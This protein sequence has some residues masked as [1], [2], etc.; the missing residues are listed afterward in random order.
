MHRYKLPIV[1][2]I[3]NNNGIYSG[4]ET[5]LYQDI[6]EGEEPRTVT[7]PPTAL[8]PSVQYD[9]MSDMVG[10]GAQGYMVST[11]AEIDSAMQQAMASDRL[12]VIN[13]MINPMAS[14]KAQQ[15]EWLTRA[16]L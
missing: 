14:R 3:I 16:K 13:V 5:E 10:A 6:T 9:K 4:F 7:S 2:V 15:H 12:S 8:L 1:L 11:Q